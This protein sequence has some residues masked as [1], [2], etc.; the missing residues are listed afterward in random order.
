MLVNA[1]N[2]PHFDFLPL[3]GCP[4]QGVQVWAGAAAVHGD[5][6]DGE[7]VHRAGVHP[8]MDHD[9]IHD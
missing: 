9:M 6:A 7:E 1:K 5:E 4:V 3:S 8:G 2:G